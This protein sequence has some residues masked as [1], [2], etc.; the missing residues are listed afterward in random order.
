MSQYSNAI[1]AGAEDDSDSDDDYWMSNPVRPESSQTLAS[2]S[3]IDPYSD[4]CTLPNGNQ[5]SVYGGS[6]K[7]AIP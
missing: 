6:D 7:P 1:P 3:Q 2:S 4:I 5:R